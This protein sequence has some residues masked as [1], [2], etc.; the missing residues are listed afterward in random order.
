[1]C[2][3][4]VVKTLDVESRFVFTSVELSENEVLDCVVKFLQ[5]IELPS[6]AT[7]LLKTLLVNI[8]YDKT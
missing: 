8:I 7:Y 5:P 1:M 6:F 3:V 4:R 2:F